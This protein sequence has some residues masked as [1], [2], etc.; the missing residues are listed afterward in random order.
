MRQHVRFV[1]GRQLIAHFLSTHVRINIVVLARRDQYVTVHHYQPEPGCP[2]TLFVPC[3]ASDDTCERFDAGS[4]ERCSCRL[5][6]GQYLNLLVSLQCPVIRRQGSNEDVATE[7]RLAIAALCAGMRLLSLWNAVDSHRVDI[8]L[9]HSLIMHRLVC[10]G[11]AADHDNILSSTG[12][13]LLQSYN[14][15][16]SE[17][18]ELW[19]A[20]VSRS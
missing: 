7:A 8:I 12:A 9:V 2:E 18:H 20:L 17:V 1:A 19:V 13:G 5:V 3:C 16:P 14:S 10:L 6:P 15:S 4:V 11:T